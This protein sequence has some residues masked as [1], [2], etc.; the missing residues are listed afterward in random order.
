MV[1]CQLVNTIVTAVLEE[2]VVFAFKEMYT[3]PPVHRV[4]LSVMLHVKWLMCEADYSHQ[5][6]AK[7]KNVWSH[8]AAPPY[9]FVA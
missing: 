2:L 4:S 3:Q 6:I 9:T 5:S 8:F 1:L 7:V